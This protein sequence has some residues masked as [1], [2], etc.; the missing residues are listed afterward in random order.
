MI[1]FGFPVDVGRPVEEVFAYLTEPAS[2]PEWQ[3]TDHVEQL[4]PGPVTTG[5]RFREVRELLGCRLESTSEVS[6]HEPGSRYDIQIASP[7]ARVVDRWTLEATPAGTRV[8]FSTEGRARLPLRPLERVIAAVMERRR[9]GHHA[10][11]KQALER[12]DVVRI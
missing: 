11:L 9:R 12:R 6:A 8:R 7:Y 3:Q 5:T 4:T 2:L 1:S 10:R